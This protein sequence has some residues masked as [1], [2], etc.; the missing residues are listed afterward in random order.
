[1]P[2]E[3]S[4]VLFNSIEKKRVEIVGQNYEEAEYIFL[5]NIT[6]VNSVLN[7]K[8]KIPKNFTK[9][10]ELTLNNSIV[11]SIYKNLNF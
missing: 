8:Y 9:I 5:N 11:Y 6:E 3:R 2:L 10:S 4:L 1:M 7:E